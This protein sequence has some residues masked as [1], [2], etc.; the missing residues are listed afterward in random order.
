M[1]FTNTLSSNTGDE[2]KCWQRLFG[3]DVVSGSEIIL[4]YWLDDW[5]IDV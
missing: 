2:E 5:E 4:L 3:V 1:P